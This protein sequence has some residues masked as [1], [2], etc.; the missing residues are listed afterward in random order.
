MRLT[1]EQ[2]KQAILIDDRDVREAAV[3]YFARSFSD[4]LGVMPLGI[5]V[6][7]RHRWIEAFETFSFLEYLRQ[8]D[9]T[10]LWLIDQIRH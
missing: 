9:E 10:V 7:Q 4:D 1:A 8:T 5:Q 6:L 3:N 2:V